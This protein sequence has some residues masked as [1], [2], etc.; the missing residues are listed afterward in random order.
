MKGLR[1]SVFFILFLSV[2]PLL[3][4]CAHTHWLFQ[5]RS[6]V[7]EERVVVSFV[8]P[9]GPA[10]SAL[11]Q[12]DEVVSINGLANT[13]KMVFRRV[14]RKLRPS[15]QVKLRVLRR[16]AASAA[17]TERLGVAEPKELTAD[18]ADSGSASQP[19]SGRTSVNEGD[20][21][22][23][24]EGVNGVDGV[25][26]AKEANE[27]EGREGT[28]LKPAEGGELSVSFGVGAVLA[29][30]TRAEEVEIL[31][32][33]LAQNEDLRDALGG[34]QRKLDALL[35][36]V[37]DKWRN[38]RESKEREKKNK[39]AEKEKNRRDRHAVKQ[40]RMIAKR[41][42]ALVRAVREEFEPVEN[43]LLEALGKTQVVKQMWV[44][45]KRGKN[46]NTNSN[47]VVRMSDV[48]RLLG[49]SYPLIKNKV[50]IIYVS[51]FGIASVV[52]FHPLFLHY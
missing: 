7:P 11:R 49:Q 32:G 6:V 28:A 37:A 42:E 27:G 34:L 20:R 47:A 51:G 13:S 15:Q 4:L 48:E 38:Q 45:C 5:G 39:Q 29:A 33:V 52:P 35:R 16:E 46:G 1:E 44:D 50:R 14:L 23:G 30:G 12:G 2:F 17:C 43:A 21:T 3:I 40:A 31:Q 19:A 9:N 10:R 24:A 22:V 41:K 8:D 25:T 18:K 36:Q 26:E